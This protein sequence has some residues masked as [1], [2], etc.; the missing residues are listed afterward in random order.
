MNQV[1]IE[2]LKSERDICKIMVFGTGSSWRRIEEILRKD[3][4]QDISDGI[5][6]LIDN[7]STKWGTRLNGIEVVGP[8]IISDIREEV[9]I[10]IA[11]SF[12]N[13]IS[14][15]LG[16]YGLKEEYHY[17]NNVYAFTAIMN[18]NALKKR[19]LPFKDIHKGKRAF[20]IGNGP[21]LRISDLNK[22]KNEITLGCNKIYLA[23]DETDWR[24]DYFVAVDSV[25]INNCVE[26]IKS[27]SMK[28]FM[29]LNSAKF[30]NKLDA[31][32]CYYKHLDPV[33]ESDFSIDI[34]EGIFGGWTVAYTMLQI[35]FYMGI[36]EVYL[37]GV[38]F[39]Y[40]IPKKIGETSECG[41]IIQR[42]RDIENHFHKDYIKED[43][44]WIVP[45][46][47]KQYRAF[48]CARET[49]NRYNRTIFNASRKTELDAF[50][51]VDF[52]SIFG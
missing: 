7:D 49:F 13:E 30:F 8:G 38:D 51:I 52:D 37:L 1:D 35:A 4:R 32:F 15:Q 16:E 47:D 3:T 22:L 19:I 27:L 44:C 31:D 36:T 34:A 5:D 33:S 18:D 43:E 21:S 40:G 2:K 23:F 29:P 41:N 11:S 39:K 12:Y 46:M 10:L 17:T 28:K 6:Y 26:T 45:Q 24:P 25:F 50:P 9:F 20:I 48:L 42:G 14:I